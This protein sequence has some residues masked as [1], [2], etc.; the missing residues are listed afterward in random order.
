MTIILNIDKDKF[1]LNGIPYFKNFMPHVIDSKLRIVN[2]YDTNFELSPL[3]S[4]DQYTVN[5]VV[6]TTI[7]ALQTALLSVVF[8]RDTLGAV[9]EFLLGSITPASVPTGTGKAFWNATQAGTYTNFGGLVVN[10]NSIATITRDG[11]GVF[12][13]SQT[14]LDLTTY[15]KIVDGNKINPWTA[16]AYPSGDQVNYLS[17]DWYLTGPAI[18]TDI[19]GTSVLWKERLHKADLVVGKN[20]FNYLNAVATIGFF[21]MA[22]GSLS[23]N[24]G[25]SITDYIPVT[26]GT[27]YYCNRFNYTGGAS[28]AF[29]NAN[30]V[31]I[32]SSNALG[33]VAPTGAVFLRYSINVNTGFDNVQI[34]TGT[35]GTTYEAYIKTVPSSQLY[36]IDYAKKTDITPI[37]TQANITKADLVVGKNLFNKTALTLNYYL[38]NATLY[39]SANY[40]VSDYM[41]VLANTQYIGT[42][43]MRFISYFDANKVNIANTLINVVTFTTVANV[44]FVRVSLSKPSTNLDTFQLE[45]GASTTVYTP[46]ALVL[47]DSQIPSNVQKKT[48]AVTLID[49]NVTEPKTTFFDNSKNLFN[50]AEATLGFYVGSLDG[51]LAGNASYNASGF[52]PVTAG[53]NYTMSYKHQIAW[54]NASKVYISGSSSTDGVKTQLAP[55]GAFYLR[56]TIHTTSYGTFQVELGST[57]TSYIAYGFIFK[58]KY[59]DKYFNEIN[60]AK[61]DSILGND[62]KIVSQAN[63]ALDSIIEVTDFPFHLKKG[64]SMSIYADITT[65]G[66]I[67]Y[68]KGYG[69]YRGEYFTIDATNIYQYSDSILVLTKTHGLTINTFIKSSFSVDDSG[70]ANF[71]LQSKTGYFKT[72]FQMLFEMNFE[73]FIRTGAQG[74][75]NVKLTCTSKEFRQ[76]VWAFGDSYFGVGSGRWPGTMKTFGYFNFLING[77]A[78]QSS[79]GAYADLQRCLNYGTPRYIVWCLGMNDANADFISNLDS[80]KALCTAKSIKLI[81]STTP[82]VPT[83]DKEVI[84]S[85]VLASGYRYI[86]F[87]KAMGAN[88]SGIW[89]TDYLNADGVHPNQIGADALALQVLVDF[90]ELMQYGKNL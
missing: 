33:T 29:Y 35:V 47:K 17:K 30:K 90:P 9:N 23:A 46:Y 82:T 84:K 85:T 16:K 77:L 72:T 74:I 41:P 66:T 10:A 3:A 73:P 50:P 40:D 28:Y 32:S 27:A 60:L 80:L 11:A 20:K 75:T 88:A 78:G 2:V 22:D 79:G 65:F 5:G 48:D 86:D 58:K 64:I 83:R 54:Y 1:S 69:K 61:Y 38:D 76:P 62:G 55:T 25:Y 26:V 71:I 44:A 67:S 36:L 6:H 56:C 49:G 14:A 43:Q 59:I 57:Q 39:A 21:I 70:V 12:S 68:G 4:I 8:S 87:Y 34:E 7:L 37:V 24:A 63:L 51:N 15:Q 53:Q 31:F 19:P 81:L 52:I 13:I 89:Y 42:S 45:L 18:A